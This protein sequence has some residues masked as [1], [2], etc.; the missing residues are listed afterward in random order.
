MQHYPNESHVARCPNHHVW[1][2]DCSV[3][4]QS[5][6]G[7]GICP[8]SGCR[9]DFVAKLEKGIPKM[10][11]RIVGGKIEAVLDIVRI[12]GKEVDTDD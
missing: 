6:K 4:T 11:N 10:V 2:H 12:E 1:L 8:V 5:G 3:D 7:T 9:F